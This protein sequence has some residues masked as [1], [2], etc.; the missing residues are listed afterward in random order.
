MKRP[1]PYFMHD[2]VRHRVAQI[3]RGYDRTALIS[4][5]MWPVITVIAVLTLINVMSVMPPT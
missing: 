4:S 2:Q 5:P 3:M 1:S